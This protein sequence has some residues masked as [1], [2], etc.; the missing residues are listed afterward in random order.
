[1]RGIFAR[2]ATHF[3]CIIAI[4]GL[5]GLH[6]SAL[7]GDE[8]RLLRTTTEEDAGAL[9]VG[10]VIPELQLRPLDGDETSMVRLLH[11]RKGLVICMTS[12]SCPL[13]V[14]YMPRLAG[15]EGEYARRG[16]AF[17]FVNAVDAENAADMQTVIR[18][19]GLKGPY[20]A[21]RRHDIQN[22]LDARTTTEVFVLDAMRKLVY[23]G[24]VDDQYGV[25]VARDEPRNPYL[26]DALEAM[27]AGKQPA[28]RATWPPGC[29]L[30]R[31]RATSMPSGELTYYGRIAHIMAENCV[32]CHRQ[33]GVAPFSLEAMQSV[34]GRVS[35]IEA[36]VRDR[37]MPPGHEV[38]QDPA[39]A[40]PWVS[41]FMLEDDDRAA[42]LSWL[43]SDRPAGRPADG[44]TIPPLPGTW[45][46]GK[47]DLVVMTPPLVLPVNGP[48]QYA[49][50]VVPTEADADRWISDIE[51]R[52]MER[53]SVH[54]A[55]V[56]IMPPGE[57]LPKLSALPTNLEL[58]GAYS[59]AD[60]TI[61]YPAGTARRLP[62]GALLLIDLY[63]RPM[64]RAKGA[65]LR[66]AMRF[67]ARPAGAEIRSLVVT[68]HS[69][70]IAPHAADVEHR[71]ELTLQSSTRIRAMTPY[72]RARG[73]S[74]E[75]SA[76]EVG[77]E[78]K[79]ILHIERY[80][81]RWPVRYERSEPLV[82]GAGTRLVLTGRFD[83]STDHISNP[84]PA[85]AIEAGPRAVDEALLVVI[86]ME[87]ALP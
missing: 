76:V 33:G 1:M 73:H 80:D 29:V 13:A 85:A 81:F 50:F 12:T 44:P 71:A 57:V 45:A 16:L 39:A 19:N 2:P 46:I 42:L 84:D 78:G 35:M 18:Q 82:L 63:A 75:L 47:P 25:G 74:M 34:K 41:D 66:T 21:D 43:R 59:P 38:K 70:R 69:L 68:D 4:A 36:V 26:R 8:P 32:G 51:F 30:D 31:D 86:E 54:H 20:I 24:A 49:R 15:L 22:A 56:W 62:A 72:M 77:Q 87:S 10:R 48:M 61:R 64:G 55:L 17:A 40:S 5:L 58:L 83:N 11:G 23:R 65:R 37:L 6:S 7:A 3:L 9:G 60:N 79:P 67:A 27:L 52:P 28:V 53:D 14:R